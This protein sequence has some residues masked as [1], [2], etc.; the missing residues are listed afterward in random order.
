MSNPRKLTISATEISDNSDAFV[1]AEIGHN[2][3]GDLEL[4]EKFFIE[5]AAAGVNAVKLQKR[6]NKEL[7]TTNF[8]NSPYEGP[9]SFGVTYGKH[10][11]F[12]EFGL[13]EYKHLIEFAKKLDLIFFATAFDFKSADF[14]MELDV[15]AI[16]VAS[17]DLKSA[18]LISYLSKFNIPLILSTGGSNLSDIKR[19]M[20][21]VDPENVGLLQCTAAY[22]AEAEDMNLNVINQFR[23]EFPNTVIGLSSHDRGISFPVTA[24]ALGARI[25]EKHF[26]LDRSM[27]GTD[28]SYSLEPSG[29]KKMVRDLRLTRIAMGN[30]KKE[31]LEKEKLP[32][33]KMGKMLVYAR[34][35][36]KGKVLDLNDFS[37]KS[38]QDG[39]NPQQIDLLIG[40][41]LILDVKENDVVRLSDIG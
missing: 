18:P 19:A 15:P 33:R 28:H 12:L 3:Q 25:I 26:T 10:R 8:Y 27:K 1:I 29:M 30:G 31:I 22:P 13:S 35:I 23:N 2:H 21:D 11:E 32:V 14:L 16:K 24:Y 5:A 38:P 17:G 6:N 41:K 36:N 9:T 34:H 39:L 7:Y 20:E 40:K 4:C 37:I